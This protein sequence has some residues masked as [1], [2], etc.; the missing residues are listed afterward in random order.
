MAIKY[1]KVSQMKPKTAKTR[2]RT[3]NDNIQS[4]SLF[5][6]ENKM[7]G[8]KLGGKKP[9]RTLDDYSLDLMKLD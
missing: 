2:K 9:G 1:T 3:L 8:D 7:L 4:D 5:K 6:L